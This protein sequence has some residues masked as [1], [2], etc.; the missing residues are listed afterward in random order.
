MK[1]KKKNVILKYKSDYSNNEEQYIFDISEIDYSP[2]NGNN[3]N[4]IITS[5]QIRSI[6]NDIINSKNDLVSILDLYYNEFVNKFI[7][8][9]DMIDD[10][11]KFVINIDILQ[12]KCYIA[13]KYNYCK[14]NIEKRNKSFVDFTGIRHCLIEHLNTRETYVSNDIDLGYNKNGI[15][16]YGTNAVG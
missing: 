14:P 11:I 4:V 10:L 5:P 16:L 1:V 7:E 9:S 3:S 15:L 8:K 2:Y 6:A 12:C 13:E